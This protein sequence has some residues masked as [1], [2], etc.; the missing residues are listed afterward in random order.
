V[1]ERINLAVE[2]LALLEIVVGKL[3]VE[4]SHCNIDRLPGIVRERL[5]SIGT[6]VGRGAAAKRVPRTSRSH[7]DRSGRSA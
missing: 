7:P 2:R 5:C 6:P 1:A 4:E 3:A